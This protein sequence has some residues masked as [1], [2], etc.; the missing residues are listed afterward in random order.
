MFTPKSL[1]GLAALA[2]SAL[3]L[4]TSA[5]AYDAK[6]PAFNRS[7]VITPA[8]P[9]S[10]ATIARVQPGMSRDDITSLIGV[11][12]RTMRFPLSDTIA[13]DYDFVDAWGYASEFSVVF[14]DAGAVVGKVASRKDY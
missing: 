2:S 11:P 8:H 12:A 9:V 6:T 7:M 3:I 5:F 13:W 4:S 14:N 10:D 1:R